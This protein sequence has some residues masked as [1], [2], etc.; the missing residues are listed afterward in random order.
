MGRKSHQFRPGS[1]EVFERRVVPAGIVGTAVE[2]PTSGG[3]PDI[4]PGQDLPFTGSPDATFA[5]FE[6]DGLTLNATAVLSTGRWITFAVY[7]APGGG[8]SDATVENSD[9]NLRSQKLVFSVT[10]FVSASTLSTFSV[11]LAQIRQTLGELKLTGQRKLQVD[12]FVADGPEGYA[13]KKL[14]AEVLDGHLISG[15]LFDY[16]DLDAAGRERR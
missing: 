1:P 12:F 2:S 11:D 15:R 6:T 14:S 4:P 8:D 10:R 3:G 5:G 7:T 13:P 9:Y 16:S